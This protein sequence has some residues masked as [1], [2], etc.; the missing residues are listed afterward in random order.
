MQKTSKFIN[1]SG[2]YELISKSTKPVA[3]IFMDKYF[4][5]IMPEIRK[6][7]QY[8]LSKQDNDKTKEINKER[9]NFS[10]EK[11]EPTLLE[12]TLF[13]LIMN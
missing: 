12:K 10:L 9:S 8:I 3:R 4:T 11:L 7:G 5:D 2:L 13:F 1:E 6:N